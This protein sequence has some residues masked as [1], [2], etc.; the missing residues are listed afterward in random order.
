MHLHIISSILPTHVHVCV[1]ES[2]EAA[3]ALVRVSEVPLSTSVL[4]S[5]RDR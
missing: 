1:P 3:W 2:A 5:T 4:R